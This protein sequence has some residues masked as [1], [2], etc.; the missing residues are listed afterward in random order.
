MIARTALKRGLVALWSLAAAA[1]CAKVTEDAAKDAATGAEAA[2]V[3]VPAAAVAAP[4]VAVDAPDPVRSAS[5]DSVAGGRQESIDEPS[6]SIEEPSTEVEVSTP[7]VSST[8]LTPPASE[9]PV[10]GPGAPASR[11]PERAA[12]LIA[13]SQPAADTLD[14]TSLLARLRKTKALNLRTKLAVK[15]ESD[16]LMERFRA[17]HAQ[18]G[19]ATLA[20]LR[21]SYDSL[22]LR[23]HSLLEDADPPL[24]RD[25]DRSRAA[26]WTLLADPMKF[27]SSPPIVASRGVPPA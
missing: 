24:A 25:I 27:G 6:A 14:V 10:F 7:S 5:V 11:E 22:F 20:E 18:H 8:D 1:G 4:S 3:T 21:R 17:Y 13:S 16:D 9:R 12:D 26:I 23:L 2:T 15:N 19:T